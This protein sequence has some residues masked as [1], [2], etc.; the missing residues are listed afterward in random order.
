MCSQELFFLHFVMLSPY[1]K[2]FQIQVLVFKICILWFIEIIFMIS[3]FIFKVMK[4][5]QLSLKWGCTEEI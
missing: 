1:W 4:L 2:I 3:E 5:F